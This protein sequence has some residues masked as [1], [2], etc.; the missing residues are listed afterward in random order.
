MR[1]KYPFQ[2]RIPRFAG[3]TTALQGQCP[4]SLSREGSQ[5]TQELGFGAVSMNKETNPVPP[6]L[7][8]L[9]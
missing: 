7:F 6:I 5:G 1:N 4:I 9:C 3:I 2:L 8:V